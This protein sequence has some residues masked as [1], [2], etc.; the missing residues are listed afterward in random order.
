MRGTNCREAREPGGV[1][2]RTGPGLTVVAVAWSALG[3]H[4]IGNRWSSPGTNGHGRHTGTAGHRHS[5]PE[6]QGAE[7]RDGGFKSPTPRATDRVQPASKLGQLVG[8]PELRVEPLPRSAAVPS[9]DPESAISKASMRIEAAGQR[10]AERH[11]SPIH[12]L[13]RQRF[14]GSNP[15][16][17][18]VSPGI[19]TPPGMDGPVG[20]LYC[21]LGA[22]CGGPAAR[23]NQHGQASA[24]KDEPGEEQVRRAGPSGR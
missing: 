5:H 21:L 15:W 22:P 12:A 16:G 2:D 3:P 9:F 1:R 11:K 18:R 4:G 10:H 7:R 23:A 17:A 6:S 8:V 20:K 14:G 13:L 19:S 24:A